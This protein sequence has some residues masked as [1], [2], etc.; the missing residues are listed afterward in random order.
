M[1][2]ATAVL[3]VL[4]MSVAQVTISAIATTTSN[5]NQMESDAIAR[6]V[7]D[8]MAGDIAGM[9]KRKDVDCVCKEMAA[10]MPMK[11]DDRLFFFAEAPA[12][13]SGT[14]TSDSV[15]LLGYRISSSS[16][17]FPNTPVLE[18][19]SKGLQWDGGGNTPGAMA[20]LSCAGG[21]ATPVPQTT[22]RGNWTDLLSDTSNDSAYH[23]LAN[24]VFRMEVCYLLKPYTKP[25][26]TVAPGKYS[27]FPFS[28]VD[29]A[30]NA[31]N[32]LQDVSAIVVAIA[33]LDNTS[34]K[35]VPNIGQCIAAISAKLDDA[36]ESDYSGAQPNLMAG[37][38]LKATQASNFASSGIPKSVVAQVR[39][40]QRHF[41][42]QSLVTP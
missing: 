40:Y 35:K 9:V 31:P 6:M 13:F 37:K 22:L 38:W 36:A 26:G 4:I 39:V 33:I 30:H 11:G 23:V 42:L 41:S 18:R 19:L 10:D 28:G 2:V 25:D 15:A 32:G 12:F 5:R 17:Y 16:P 20:F 3:T 14:A 34:R 27:V 7:F 24:Q 1:L 29:A 8:R 21:A